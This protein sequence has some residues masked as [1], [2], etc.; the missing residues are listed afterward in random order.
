MI[1][2]LTGK[3]AAGKGTVAD[4][5]IARGFVY[6]S[7]S[8][9]L[10]E[11]LARRGVAESRTSLMALGNELRA[12]EGPDALAQR[13]LERLRD[14]RDHL[15]DSIR[16]PAEVAT[17]RK[18]P[19]FTLLGIDADPEVRFRRLIER[20]RQGDPLTWEDFRALEA[21]ETSSDDPAAQQLAATFA[22][23]DIV[24]MNDGPVDALASAVE[25]VLEGLRG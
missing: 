10:R 18:L 20:G 9:V 19:D 1:I 12:A 25:R 7:L 11:E 23:A 8:D 13:I 16:T 17:L 15:V 3:F 21:R 22:L 4:M 2:G 24:V 14:G 6:H 5:L